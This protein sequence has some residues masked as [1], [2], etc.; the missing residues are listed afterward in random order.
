[1]LRE[2]KITFGEMR[3]VGVPDRRVLPRLPS[4]HSTNVPAD[5]RPDHLR[6]PDIEPQFVCNACSKRG[7]DVRPDY[8]GTNK[9]QLV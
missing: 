7:A 6:L 4:S 3:E 9:G 8:K 2:Q 1:M 5:R